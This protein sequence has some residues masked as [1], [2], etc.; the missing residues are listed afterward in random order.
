MDFKHVSADAG[1]F[2]LD[3]KVFFFNINVTF[4]YLQLFYVNSF[5]IIL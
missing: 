2:L 3:N 1:W 5:I 4:M